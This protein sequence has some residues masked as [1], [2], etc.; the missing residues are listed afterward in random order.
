MKVRIKGDI[1]GSRDGI[2]WPKRGETM[3][4]PDDEGTALCASGLAVPAAD[5]DD[6]VETAVP[7][8]ADVEKHTGGLTKATAEAVAPGAPEKPD[9]ESAENDDQESATAADGDQ[10][11]APAK[12]AAAPVKKTAAKR[13]PAKPQAESK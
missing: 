12:K 11:P 3:E 2:P 6:D 9:P 13:P 5:T 1:S 8:D 4:L 10:A 7:D